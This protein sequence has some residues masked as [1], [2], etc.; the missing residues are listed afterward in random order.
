MARTLQNVADRVRTLAG[1]LSGVMITDPIITRWVNDAQLDVLRKTESAKADVSV[2]SVANTFRYPVAGGFLYVDAIYYNGTLLWRRSKREID[3][4][5]RY[6]QATTTSGTPAYYW[7]EAD[8][9]CLYPTPQVSGDTVTVTRIPRP[10]D[11]V[12]LTDVLTI[13]DDQLELIVERC[14]QKAKEMEEDYT[15]ASWF[16][17][18][19]KE[20]TAESAFEESMRGTDSYPVVRDAPGENW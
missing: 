3:Y 10:V 8:A 20:E 5:D 16:K 15:A 6:R 18:Q 7:L 9:V 12:N 2:I 4:Q 11:L 17:A 13:S 19:Y 1:D 14:L